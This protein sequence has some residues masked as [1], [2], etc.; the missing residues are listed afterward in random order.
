MILSVIIASIAIICLFVFISLRSRKINRQ[1][2]ITIIKYKSGWTQ[3]S[4][5]IYYFFSTDHKKILPKILVKIILFNNKFQYKKKLLTDGKKSSDCFFI[6][7]YEINAENRA[8]F[9]RARATEQPNLL[10]VNDCE[11]RLD[12]RVKYVYYFFLAWSKLRDKPLK[13]FYF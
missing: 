10:I 11:G 1:N 13:N 12:D 2:W 4:R 3:F 5:F 8:D 7:Y 9:A 6:Y